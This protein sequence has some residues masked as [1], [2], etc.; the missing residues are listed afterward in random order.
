MLSLPPAPGIPPFLAGRRVLVLD[1]AVTV[2]TPAD[3]PG[4]QRILDEMLSP[5]AAVAEPVANTWAPASPQALPLTHMDPQRPVPFRSG[6][7]LIQE[8]DEAGWG[9][10]L[11]AAPGLLVL[12]LRQLGGAFAGPATGGGA[13]DRFAAPLLY[14]AVGV[15]GDDTDKNLTAVRSAF[16]PY[17]T[18]RTAPNF[19]NGFEEPQRSYDD[20]V[21]ARVDQ[22][23]RGAD[24]TGMFAGDVAPA[25]A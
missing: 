11:D 10:V 6:S 5:L 13:L 19:I 1:G 9:K 21:R 22:V 4:A 24:P 12:E 25:R 8:L 16:A 17:L 2:A 7:A 3:R 14:Y 20:E 18:G 15:A 23:R